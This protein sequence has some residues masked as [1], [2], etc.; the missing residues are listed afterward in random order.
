MPGSARE[1]KNAEDE[2]VEFLWLSNPKKFEGE[3][4]VQS[5]IADKIQL[6]E[7]DD[8]G[9]RKPII[10]NGSEFELQADMIIKALGF[11]PEELPK[12]FDEEELKVKDRIIISLKESLNKTW[13]NLQWS[14]YKLDN[15]DQEIIKRLTKD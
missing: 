15:K 9:R 8:S 10:Q 1:V 3:N 11:D 14:D 6:G 7:P 12:L 4:K 2:G 13:P 5:F